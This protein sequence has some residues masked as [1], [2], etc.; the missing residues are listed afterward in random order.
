MHA[1]NFNGYVI[2]FLIHLTLRPIQEQSCSIDIHALHDQSKKLMCFYI[3][4][5]I[6]CLK[7]NMD[8]FFCGEKGNRD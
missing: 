2:H 1:T 5:Y 7:G 8:F 4:R 6:Y 3:A